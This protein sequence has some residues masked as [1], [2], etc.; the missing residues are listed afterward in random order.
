MV[1]DCTLF[2]LEDETIEKQAVEQVQ[3]V[4]VVVHDEPRR[5]EGRNSLD[6][7]ADPPYSAKS[8]RRFLQFHAKTRQRRTSIDGVLG[9]EYL[10]VPAIVPNS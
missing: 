9:Y 6:E 7:V 3:P 10:P 4:V 1:G 8:N 5:N 2:S